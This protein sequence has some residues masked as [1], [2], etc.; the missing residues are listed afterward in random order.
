MKKII[1][2][3]QNRWAFG[4]VHNGLCK[5]LYKFDLLCNIFDWTRDYT[6]NEIDMIADCYDLIV[7][8]PE[9]AGML[10]F[11]YGVPL[12][13][14]I[15]IS[16]AQWDILYTRH[17]YGLEFLKDLKNYSVISNIL[18]I[19]SEE[20]GCPVV[21]EIVKYGIHFDLFYSKPSDR[22][23]NV[24]YAGIKKTY[25]FYNQEIKRGNLSDLAIK[26]AGLNAVNNNN[27][28][29]LCMPAYYKKIDAVIMSST[30]EGGGL[31]MLEG[32][33]AG[34]LC[35]GTPVGYFEENID[36]GIIVPIQSGDFVLQ[37]TKTLE[38]YKNNSKE[39]RQK[40]V[41]IQEYARYNYDWSRVIDKWV[42]LFKENKQ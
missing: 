2:F 23:V 38:Y 26:L 37:T 15:A 19:K 18:K 20:F 5:E 27:Y 16:H 21:P 1:F 17:K 14:M 34:K 30:E 8:N 9:F 39:Y 36:G 10:H 32:A 33:A 6:K 42:T 12:D 4:S 11:E 3:T 22:L 25:N 7:T 28:N 31:P 29:F 40:C 35:V 41:D 13:K 24:G